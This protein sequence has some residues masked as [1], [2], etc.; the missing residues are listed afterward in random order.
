MVDQLLFQI[1][2]YQTLIFVSRRTKIMASSSRTIPQTVWEA[3]KETILH[4]RFIEG[5]PLSNNKNGGRTVMEVMREDH[6]F[7]AT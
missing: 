7:E 5:L 2:F 6:Q 4:L 3:Q 1:Y